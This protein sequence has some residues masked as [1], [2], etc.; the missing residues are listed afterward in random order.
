MKCG[1]QRSKS[2]FS[3]TYTERGEKH[4]D[5]ENKG[6]HSEAEKHKVQIA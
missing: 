1:S 2:A 3:F 6:F 5:K 4:N